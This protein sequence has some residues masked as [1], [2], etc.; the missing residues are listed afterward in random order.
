MKHTFNETEYLEEVEFREGNK[1]W[2]Y[3]FFTNNLVLLYYWNMVCY[4][5]FDS[6]VNYEINMK[7][8]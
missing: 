3:R 8:L 5:L 2:I 1:Y 4:Y 7:V 6:V